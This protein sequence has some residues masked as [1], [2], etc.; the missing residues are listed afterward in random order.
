M[1]KYSNKV[2]D[3]ILEIGT[4]EIPSSYLLPASN[5]M[6]KNFESFL[7]ENVLTA[8][9][10]TS[11]Y[12]PRRLTL[13][14]E[15]LLFRQKDRILKIP[16]PPAKLCF[17]EA[18]S[19]TKTL[20]GF[21]KSQDVGLDQIKVTKTEKGEYVYVEK[22][23]RGR[24]TLS[25]LKEYLPVFIKSISFPKSMRWMKDDFRFARPIRW[26][27]AL[28]GDRVIRFSVADV[29]SGNYTFGHRILRPK[30]ILVKSPE[31]YVQKL[32][33][34]HVLVDPMER[35]SKIE[36]SIEEKVAQVG[37][38]WVRDEELL[39]EVNNLVEYPIC[40][41]GS[42]DPTYLRLP[43]EVILTAMK[44]HQRYFGVV[45]RKGKLISRFIAV[46]SGNE[47]YIN[48]ILDGNQKV[49]QARLADALFYW[50][51]DRKIPLE[52]RIESLKNVVWL[53]GMGNLYHK[54]ERLVRLA[55]LMASSL[56]PDRIPVVERA[57]WLSKADLVTSMIKDGKEF[58]TLEGKM[59]M[60]Y[61]LQFDEP[62]DVAIAIYEHYLPRY[63]GDSLPETP[64]GTILAIADKLD[65]I[66]GGFIAGHIPTG[67]QDPQG[68]RRN[69]TGIISIIAEKSLSI[70]LINLVDESIKAYESQ[71]LLKASHIRDEILSL[72]K[73]RIEN[74]LEEEGF[75]Y[76]LVDAVLSARYDD[77][78]DA[79]MRI[80]ALDEL[81]SSINFIK[82]IEVQKRVA[83]IMKNQPEPP[84]L[85]ESLLLEEAERQLYSTSKN[86]E[87]E[88]RKSI[89]KRDYRR[90]LQQLLSL[91]API[92]RFFDE[93]LIMAENEVVRMNRLALLKYIKNLF[94]EIGDLSKIVIE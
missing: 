11:L 20:I 17:D 81:R 25:I 48:E 64:Q 65:T 90:A 84:S 80:A 30:K 94:N 93:V 36:L 44:T 82:L 83:N 29:K 41:L 43:M 32:K 89:R 2:A 85:T 74:W 70:N 38:K 53:E 57:A 73:T 9:G 45:D 22:L 59:G 51:T 67:S 62:K 69:A 33:Q 39:A 91:R 15:K 34:V 7:H 78:S 28:Y 18:G 3:F 56:E 76:D 60:E 10:M 72:F 31:D 13:I 1:G 40:V 4:E 6:R 46:V 58:T 14:V 42:F 68:L 71:G 61:A 79:K 88:Y 37:G 63:P 49:L 8:A 52:N 12:T 5:Q 86:L 35:L 75:R 16:G 50:D 19:P 54:T 27:V 47:R 87:S 77:P 23:K 26:I 21:A 92:D 66:V 24:T 55:T